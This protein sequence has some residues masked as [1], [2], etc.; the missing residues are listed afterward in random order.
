M[1]T[2]IA[3]SRTI[4]DYKLLE[5]AI[6][7]LD[8]SITEV[9]CGCARGLDRLGELWAKNN[10][11]PIKYFPADWGQYG[12]VAGRLSNIDMAKYAEA[13]VC[14]W[15]GKSRGTKQMISQ[16]NKYKLKLSVHII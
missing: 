12:N 11:V 14:L 3:G 6:N 8:F 16:A 5:E 4:N 13:C 1:K 9:V 10:N 15:D 7:K 2:I